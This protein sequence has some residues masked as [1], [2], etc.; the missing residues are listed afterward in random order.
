MAEQE[1][2][3]GQLA[4]QM[5]MPSLQQALKANTIAKHVQAIT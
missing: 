1:A 2:G 3:S 4:G 5:Q